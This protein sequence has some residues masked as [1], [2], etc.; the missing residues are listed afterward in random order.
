MLQTLKF[1]NMY[2]SGSFSLGFPLEMR[3][4]ILP[5]AVTEKVRKEIFLKKESPV[6]YLRVKN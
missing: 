6:L 3:L 5:Q 4:L 2:L 1:P